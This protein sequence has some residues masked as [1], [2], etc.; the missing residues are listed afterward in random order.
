MARRKVTEAEKTK[1]EN[2]GIL[3]ASGLIAGEALTGVLLAS[4]VMMKFELP[5]F[6]DS[7][8]VG[9]IVYP[10]IGLVLIGIPLRSMIRD[11]AGD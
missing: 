1:I 6:G 7:P 4:L 10:I 2:R 8:L 5:R 9:L 11:T 3:L